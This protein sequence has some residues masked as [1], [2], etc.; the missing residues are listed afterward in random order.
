MGLYTVYAIIP[1][2][3]LT[4]FCSAIPTSP[5]ILKIFFTLVIIDSYILTLSIE[6]L[7]LHCRLVK[8]Y[9]AL[10]EMEKIAD[11][12][13]GEDN[14]R[15]VQRVFLTSTANDAGLCMRKFANTYNHDT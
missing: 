9:F 7:T 11:R 5:Y 13:N 1:A 8:G 14:S 15:R 12:I 3:F 2:C 4:F 6:P 10:L